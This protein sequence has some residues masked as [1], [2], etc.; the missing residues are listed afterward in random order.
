MSKY[1]S[2]IPIIPE[3]REEASPM[4]QTQVRPIEKEVNSPRLT[5][6]QF[7]THGSNYL[8]SS[9][10][11]SEIPKLSNVESNISLDLNMLK[12]LNLLSPQF[13]KATLGSTIEEPS[14]DIYGRM[15]IR[16]PNRTENSIESSNSN[17]NFNNKINH[18]HIHSQGES[19]SSG[20]SQ[21][22]ENE[23]V[24]RSCQGEQDRFDNLF[25]NSTGTM[26]INPSCDNFSNIPK[27]TRLSPDK[28]YEAYTCT[29]HSSSGKRALTED[30]FFQL[31]TSLKLEY[32]EKLL[33]LNME[34]EKLKDSEKY[35]NNMSETV[36]MAEKKLEENELK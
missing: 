28:I 18:R 34:I 16:T 30:R 29:C 13:S 1:E 31:R 10:N 23:V 9:L 24:R 26:R 6:N 33:I 21:N 11:A 15:S 36:H 22:K 17:G 20:E 8:L 27:N 5:N 14:K 19:H 4:Q 7:T 3:I 32:E 12:N 35:N 2:K 25:E